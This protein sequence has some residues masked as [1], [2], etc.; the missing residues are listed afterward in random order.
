[1]IPM[2]KDTLISGEELRYVHSAT[3]MRHIKMP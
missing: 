3:A 2:G 1:M